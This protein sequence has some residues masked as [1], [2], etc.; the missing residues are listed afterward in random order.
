MKIFNI[1]Q[2]SVLLKHGAIAIDCGL[3]NRNKTYVT[4]KEDEKF[5]ELLTKWLNREI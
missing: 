2:A 3:G 5:K 4:F 1:Y